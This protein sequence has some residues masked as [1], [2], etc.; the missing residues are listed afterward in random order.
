MSGTSSLP[1]AN[2]SPELVY[3]RIL[4][5]EKMLGPGTVMIQF[6]GYKTDLDAE[7]DREEE[8]PYESESRVQLG[9]SIQ[10]KENHCKDMRERTEK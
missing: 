1:P 4:R 6:Q 9:L 10:S 7:K 8:Q 5:G 2:P 3:S